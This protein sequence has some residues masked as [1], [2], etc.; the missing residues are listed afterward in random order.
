MDGPNPREISNVVVGEGDARSPNPEGVS[1]MMYAWGQF[2]DHDLTRTLMVYGS[3]EETAAALRLPDGH[4]RTSQGDN[5]PIQGGRFVAG[6]ARVAENP[7]LTA[8]HAVFV[9]EHN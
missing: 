8:L 9:R 3:D 7:S 2:V 4:M 1:G 5:L 6:D